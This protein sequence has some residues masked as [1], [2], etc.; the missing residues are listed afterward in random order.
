MLEM[1]PTAS[2]E[3]DLVHDDSFQGQ[4]ISQHKVL[5]RILFVVFPILRPG[6]LWNLL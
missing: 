2:H 6:Q 5:H 1:N 3:I 4:K